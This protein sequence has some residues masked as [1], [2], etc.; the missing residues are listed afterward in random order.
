MVMTVYTVLSGIKMRWSFTGRDF[1]VSWIVKLKFQ[2]L[3]DGLDLP[4]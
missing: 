3:A 4:I 1:S 2:F